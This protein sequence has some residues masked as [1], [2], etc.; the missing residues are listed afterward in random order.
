MC[1]YIAITTSPF[2]H[3]TA[4]LRK[5]KEIVN[6]SRPSTCARDIGIS[7]ISHS[8]TYIRTYV[9]ID[10]L[11]ALLVVYSTYPALSSQLIQFYLKKQTNNESMLTLHSFLQHRTLHP[12]GQHWVKST[13]SSPDVFP[14]S[15]RTRRAGRTPFVTIWVW[16][17]A[18]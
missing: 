2:S 15:R 8:S 14:T 3:Y 5:C 4:L 16:M 13:A 7:I 6:T 12:R 1:I 11:I 9:V 17:N 18:S 10:K